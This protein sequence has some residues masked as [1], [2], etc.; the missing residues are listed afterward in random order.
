MMKTQVSHIGYDLHRLHEQNYSLLMRLIP[1]LRE[2]QGEC[3]SVGRHGH[4]LYLKVLDVT[5]YTMT[6]AL[7]EYLQTGAFKLAYPD[8]EMRI[9]FDARVAEVLR[10]KSRTGISWHEPD[11]EYRRLTRPSVERLNE[12]LHHWLIRCLKNGHRFSEHISNAEA[13]SRSSIT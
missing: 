10:F 1:C 9:Y 13:E 6:L 7:T 2:L 4:I 3:Q 11:P 12:F 5:P 8:L